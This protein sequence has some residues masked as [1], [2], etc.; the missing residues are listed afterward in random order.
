MGKECSKCKEIKPEA[1]FYSNR[2]E[3]KSCTSIKHKLYN[4]LNKA[5]IEANKKEYYENNKSSIKA[6]RRKTRY[7]HLKS[8]AK[9]RGIS[10]E[11]TE[12]DYYATVYDK[13]C[14]YCGGDLPVA[15]HGLDRK[16][17]NKGY[18]LENVTTCCTVC[19]K[20]KGTTLNHDEM[21]EVAKLLIRLRNAS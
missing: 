20:I 17:N 12:E 4:K 19:N 13:K 10:L 16:D 5:K 1:A 2:A 21:K 15:G 14:S 7:V 9:R 6:I 11:L 3:C 8:A 18:T